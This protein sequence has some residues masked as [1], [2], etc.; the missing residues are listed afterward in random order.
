MRSK[1]DASPRRLIIRPEAARNSLQLSCSFGLPNKL[2]PRQGASRNPQCSAGGAP[3][4]RTALESRG[5]V[6]QNVGRGQMSSDFLRRRLVVRGVE[7][8][9]PSPPRKC[10]PCGGSVLGYS[11]GASSKDGCGIAQCG[12]RRTCRDLPW[13]RAQ[14]GESRLD[15]DKPPLPARGEANGIRAPRGATAPTCATVVAA[16]AEPAR[17]GP[18]SLSIGRCDENRRQFL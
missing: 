6:A 14:D 4:Q 1:I 17:S 9:P 5:H 18:R 11:G 7:L 10:G 13:I 8:Q 2:R 3:P 15:G 16:L 12:M